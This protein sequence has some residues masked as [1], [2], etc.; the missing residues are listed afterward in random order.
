MAPE[1]R[2]WTYSSIGWLLWFEKTRLGSTARKM[3]PLAHTN[4]ALASKSVEMG[5]NSIS[6]DVERPSE[7]LIIKR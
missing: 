4:C 5:G 2:F 3:K 1:T 7:A 6:C